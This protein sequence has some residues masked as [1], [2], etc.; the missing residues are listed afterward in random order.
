MRGPSDADSLARLRK[1][2]IDA[3]MSAEDDTFWAAT[4][5]AK[6]IVQRQLGPRRQHGV[7]NPNHPWRKK[8]KTNQ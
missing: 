6:A 3:F 4:N 5:E 1:Q 7:A 2:I 8:W